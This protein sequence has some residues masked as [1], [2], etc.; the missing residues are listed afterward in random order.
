[1]CSQSASTTQTETTFKRLLLCCRSTH[2]GVPELG[3]LAMQS[4]LQDTSEWIHTRIAQSTK[5]A[6]DGRALF[7]WFMANFAGILKKERQKGA[8]SAL[9][10]IGFQRKKREDSAEIPRSSQVSGGVLS[11]SGDYVNGSKVTAKRLKAAQVADLKVAI[12]GCGAFAK[13]LPAFNT[14]SFA[15][16]EDILAQMLAC[17]CIFQ[18]PPQPPLALSSIGLQQVPEE[19]QQPKAATDSEPNEPVADDTESSLSVPSSMAVQLQLREGLRRSFLP[20]LLRACSDFIQEVNLGLLLQVADDGTPCR[21]NLSDNWVLASVCCSCQSRT[22]ELIF[23]RA[24]SR[25]APPS[26]WSTHAWVCCCAASWPW[27][28]KTCSWC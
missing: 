25:F 12:C 1:M 26:F 8:S 19:S 27:N 4:F 17:V 11:T 6:S 21:Y 7:D 16:M 5:D 18:R 3:F 23:W 10:Q 2:S 15:D 24:S 13:C 9:R 14:Y 28:L 20:V 22:C